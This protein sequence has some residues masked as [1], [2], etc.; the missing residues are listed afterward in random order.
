MADYGAV[1]SIDRKYRSA[2][3]NLAYRAYNGGPGNEGVPESDYGWKGRT[4]PKARGKT[5]GGGTAPD[6]RFA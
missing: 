2:M 4:D 1:K 3:I 6:N 5:I